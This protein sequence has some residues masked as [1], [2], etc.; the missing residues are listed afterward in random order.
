MFKYLNELRGF[1]RQAQKGE[2]YTNAFHFIVNAHQ[3][4]DT[5]WTVVH[6]VCTGQGP[7][8][9]VR[10]GHAWVEKTFE[11]GTTL[12]F[13]CGTQGLYPKEVYHQAGRITDVVEYSFGEFLCRVSKEGHAGPFCPV[14]SKAVHN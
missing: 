6:G 7:I 12:A 14:I 5:G 2:C 4:G 10:F 13:D 8:A 9:G 11:D 1:N 3:S